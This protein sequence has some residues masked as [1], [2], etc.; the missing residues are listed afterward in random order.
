MRLGGG[1]DFKNALVLRKGEDEVLR[2]GRTG[3]VDGET[4]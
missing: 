1:R 2:D 3:F 4:I